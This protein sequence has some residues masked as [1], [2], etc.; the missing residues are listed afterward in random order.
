MPHREPTLKRYRISND[1][2][3][4]ILE[5]LNP[6]TLHKTCQAFRRVYQL[7]MEFQHLRYRFELAVVG[8]R[9]GPV[10]NSTRSSP[11][12]RLQL[13]MAYK[14]DWPSLNWTDEQKV[15][16][17]DTATQVDVSGNFLYYVGTQSLDLIELPSCRT[18]CPPSQTRH[19]KYN[20][21][22]QADCVAIDPLQSLIVT[23]QTYAGPGGQIGLRLKIR[24]LWK[25][26]KHPRAS[27]PYYDCSTHVAQPVDKVSIVVCG[28]RMVVTLDFIGGLTKHLLLDWCTLQAMW[29]EEQD[30]VLLNSYFLLGVRKV[31]G[32]MVLYLYN[33]FDMR[34]VAIEREYELPPIWAKSTMRFARN[35]APNNDV[36]TPSNALFC[37]DPS[38]RVLLLAAKQTGPN[39]SGMH[40]MFIN[41]SFFR[42][43]S[44]ADRRSVPWSYWSQFCLIKDLQM[45]AVVGNPQVVGSRVVYLEKDGTRS[46]RGHERSR[47]SIID[48]SPYA[49]ISTPPTKTWTLIGKMSVLRPN[50]S[51]RDFPSA[52]T[53]G[54]AVE[55]ICAT[56]DNVV[57]L[58]VCSSHQLM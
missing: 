50:E 37:S 41:E 35:T 44:H 4:L 18:G 33:I 27:S 19:L 53:N 12:I 8:M 1:V 11:L 32:K 14:K 54:L 6:V 28:N 22:P 38:A 42:P 17:P 48:F 5:K 46:S 51:H 7:V 52:T 29:L 20:T 43:T 36:C 21:T 57:V 24:N 45:N 40:W 34:N 30:V 56:E 49:E 47:L 23:S 16:V 9:D 15:R 2:L 39:G 58:L 31:H 26:D 55:G 13:L 25:F 3:I 10:S